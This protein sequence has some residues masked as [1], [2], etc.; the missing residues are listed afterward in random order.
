[1]RAEFG[2]S[3]KL[4]IGC[5]GRFRTEKNQAFLL[6]V[7]KE[8][9][10]LESNTVL[11]FAGDG[12]LEDDV[13]KKAAEMGLADKCIF[14]GMR[15]DIPDVMQAMDVL[16]MPSLFEGL[17]VTGIEAQAGGL[18]VIAPTGIPEEM[19]AIDMVEFIALD[20]GERI[21]AEKLVVKAKQDKVDT[22]E[23]IKAAKYDI[24]TLVP[25][26]QE[27]YLRSAND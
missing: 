1:M 26:L 22:I 11:L 4:V 16:A 7:L 13:K 24:H 15:S 17:P 3:D 25:W 8:A 2:V 12:P 20:A 5:V 27:F 18:S 9:L 14:L 10:L 19:N 6:G 21:W 23:K